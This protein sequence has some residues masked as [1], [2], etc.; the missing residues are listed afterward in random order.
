MSSFPLRVLDAGAAKPAMMYV[1]SRQAIVTNQATIRGGDGRRDD[2]GDEIA[3]VGGFL[4]LPA[5]SRRAMAASS[6]CNSL[7]ICAPQAR[8]ARHALAR[9]LE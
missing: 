5:I 2:D 9:V 6:R 7:R 1:Q 8:P 4:R 3:K